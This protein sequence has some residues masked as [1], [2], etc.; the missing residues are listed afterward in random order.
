MTAI[1][2]KELR[3]YFHGMMG[4]VFF[5]LILLTFGI[6]TAVLSLSKGYAD[7]SLVPYNAQFVYLIAIPLLTMRSLS[8]ER[9]AHTDQLLYSSSLGSVDIVLGQ[10]L[11]SVVMLAM[12]LAVCCLYP[13]VL[14]GYGRVCARHRVRK[15]CS[16]SFCSAARFRPSACFFGDY[17]IIRCLRRHHVLRAAVLLL[18]KRPWRPAL[19]EH[20]R[21]ASAVLFG[22]ISRG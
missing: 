3:S 5:A 10:Y 16:R 22:V 7:F 14:S 9:R 2:K 19:R 18:R 11:T 12:P 17:D 1:A 13:L 6:Y 21:G 20:P 4:W 15:Q 8:E